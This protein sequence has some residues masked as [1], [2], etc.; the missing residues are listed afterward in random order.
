MIKE[1]YEEIGRS[2]H[3]GMVYPYDKRTILMKYMTKYFNDKIIV[4]ANYLVI[5]RLKRD[6]ETYGDE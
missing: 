6:A 3:D 2:E 4:P 5:A 1:C